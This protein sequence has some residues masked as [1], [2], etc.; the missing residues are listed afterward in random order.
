MTKQRWLESKDRAELLVVIRKQTAMRLSPA[1]IA[2][3]IRGH[4]GASVT[5]VWHGACPFK[6][7][8]LVAADAPELDG[9]IFRVKRID[10]D[11]ITLVVAEQP[12]E[13]V[14]EEDFQAWQADCRG[15]WV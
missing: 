8:D 15:E 1:E 7:D 5:A 4:S 11:Q 2:E 6:I 9:Y 12:G 14:E 10:A 13:D 3:A